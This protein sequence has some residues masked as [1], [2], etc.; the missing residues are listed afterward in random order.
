MHSVF[1]TSFKSNGK[2]SAALTTI[3]LL[4]GIFISM[5]W[6]TV[7]KQ[8]QA[9]A[10]TTG[11]QRAAELSAELSQTLEEKDELETQLQQAQQKISAYEK[12]A[13]GAFSAV[14]ISDLEK[15][16]VL[17]G[18]TDVT[19]RGVTVELNDSQK[20][21]SDAVDRSVLLIHDED[22]LAVVNELNAAGCEAMSINDQR[23]IATTAIRCV[24]PVVSVNGVKV[25]A[26]FII[27]AIGDPEVLDAALRLPGGVV[28][29]L[30]PWGIEVNIKKLPSV[31]VPKYSGGITAKEAK[32]VAP[33]EEKN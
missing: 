8:T 17:A 15:T 9:Q 14:L 32:P 18:L 20:S 10:S 12:T 26:P 1:K 16:R 3:C 19:G 21:F 22:I 5:Q 29:S 11:V 27:T 4:L 25:G 13:G 30:A 23:I 31:T 33:E 2:A 6:K 7:Q 28:D 24:G